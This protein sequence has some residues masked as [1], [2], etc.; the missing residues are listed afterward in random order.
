MTAAPPRLRTRWLYSVAEHIEPGAIKPREG[1]LVPEKSVVTPDPL[2]EGLDSEVPSRTVTDIS[3]TVVADPPT[4]P[5]VRTPGR[6]P[7]QW[8]GSGEMVKAVAL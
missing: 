5:V 1:D 4:A 2:E 8:L 7:G 6:V 3:G